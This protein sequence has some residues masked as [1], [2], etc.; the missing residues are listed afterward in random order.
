MDTGQLA[1]DKTFQST[2]LPSFHS[3]TGMSS[4]NLHIALIPGDGT[5]P[6]VTREAVKVTDAAAAK[7]GFN[8]CTPS[9]PGQSGRQA[10]VGG[11]RKSLSG[12]GRSALS[13]LVGKTVRLRFVMKDADV[14]AFRFAP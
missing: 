10:R 12:K 2:T 4:K 1:V 13:A 6:E 7:F 3:D 5:G 9:D 8:V 14:F 11:K